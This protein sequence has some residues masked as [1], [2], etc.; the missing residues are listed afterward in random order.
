M[1]ITQAASTEISYTHKYSQTSTQQQQF[2]S[3]TS[4]SSSRFHTQTSSSSLSSSTNKTMWSRSSSLEQELVAA[5]SL[6]QQQPNSRTGSWTFYKAKDKF[7]ESNMQCFNQD[8]NSSLVE[9]QTLC[10]PLD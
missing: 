9:L 4:S 7:I 10:F 1:S 8:E 6:E 5:S 3:S 2:N